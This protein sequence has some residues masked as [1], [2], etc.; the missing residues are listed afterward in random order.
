MRVIVIGGHG[1]VA[2]LLTPLLVAG[3]HEVTGVIR[4]PAHVEDLLCRLTRNLIR[5][6][7]HAQRQRL[8]RLINH[9][10][11]LANA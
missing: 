8:A 10:I 9:A 4:D 11:R 2:R 1:N 7:D 6:T 3:S 5:S